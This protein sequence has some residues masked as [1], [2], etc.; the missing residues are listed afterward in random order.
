MSVA[1][2]CQRQKFPRNS[3]FWQNTFVWIFAGL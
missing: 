2:K 3:S 1:I